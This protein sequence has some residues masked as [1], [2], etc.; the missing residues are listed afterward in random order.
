MSNLVCVGSWAF[1][2]VSLSFR[3]YWFIVWVV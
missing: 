3:G 1:G 2:S